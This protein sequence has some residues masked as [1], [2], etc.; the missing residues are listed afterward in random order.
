MTVTV[1]VGASYGDEGKGKIVD[2]LSE[3]NDVVVRYSGGANAGHTLVFDDNK[4]LVTNLI[5]SGILRDKVCILGDAM[6]IDP[7]ILIEELDRCKNA[8]L[9]TNSIHI[10][11]KA[12]I[13][14]PSH[15][16]EENKWANNKI[17]TTKKGI[18]PTYCSKVE[19]TG[20]RFEKLFDTD[21]VIKNYHITRDKLLNWQQ[22]LGK[23]CVCI[24]DVGEYL[25]E[26]IDKN[27]NILLEGA[28]GTMLDIDHGTYPYVTSSTTTAA[29]ACI[30]SGLG[31]KYIDEVIGVTKAYVTRVGNGPLDGEFDES[32]SDLYRELGHEYGSVTGR[33]RRIAPLNM[34]ELKYSC[35]INSMTQL[36]LTKLDVFSLINGWGVID[37]CKEFNQ[38]PTECKKFVE[39]IE[40][41]TNV[42]ITM[43]S[44]GP[45][46]NQT[47]YR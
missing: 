32:E 24:N 6:V 4:K 1:V 20:F 8:G 41:Q 22:L 47:I 37:N 2:L 10:S 28:Q 19:R 3:N 23:H 9:N 16:D 27:K 44:I 42:A 45:H 26:A 35:R 18:G 17:G 43:V 7:D 38:L 46:R 34:N 11:P 29:G 12:H 39:K 5:P 31:P 33:P 21:Y 40:E 25:L 13:T 14:L 15:K 36:A 30:G